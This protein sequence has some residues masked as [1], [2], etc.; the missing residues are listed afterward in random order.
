V[1]VPPEPLEFD[2]PEPPAL[3]PPVEPT[4]PPLPPSPGVDEPPLPPAPVPEESLPPQPRPPAIK[5]ATAPAIR[6]IGEIRIKRLLAVP[7]RAW[8]RQAP[9][10]AA[11]SH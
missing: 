2:P 7:D 9:P 1:D 4:T 8:S 5:N 11:G 10:N 6:M 3:D